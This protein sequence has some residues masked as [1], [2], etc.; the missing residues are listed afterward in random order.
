MIQ[1]YCKHMICKHIICYN[2]IQFSCLFFMFTCS[3]S[4]LFD[5]NFNSLMRGKLT[6]KGLNEIDI[7]VSISEFS[8]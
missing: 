3:N 2:T 4:S 5:K 7:G 6:V 8:F 1:T